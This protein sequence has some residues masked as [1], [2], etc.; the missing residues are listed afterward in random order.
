MGKRKGNNLGRPKRRVTDNHTRNT[1]NPNGR[2]GG[3][4]EEQEGE[5]RL[6]VQETTEE[7]VACRDPNLMQPAAAKAAPKKPPPQPLQITE[8]TDGTVTVSFTT[9]KEELKTLLH[10]KQQA[11]SG[12]SDLLNLPSAGS[13][14]M[15]ASP[16]LA[17]PGTP[18][19]EE[20]GTA[21]APV[22]SASSALSSQPT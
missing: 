1:N 11:S 13:T 21:S 16:V 9:T 10:S 12:F 15:H 20:N 2:K 4:V 18:V 5:T 7:S 14:T 8:N 22:E 3:T 6:A 17:L 19:L